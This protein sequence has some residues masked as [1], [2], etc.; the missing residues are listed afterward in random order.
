MKNRRITLSQL[1]GFL[2]KASE[3]L[4]G[5]M[6]ASEFKEFI[7]GML[8][9]KRM[10][11]EFDLQRR[12]LAK[13]CAHLSAE[14]LEA[15]LEDPRSYPE[16]FFVPRIARW[17]EGFVDETGAAV[18]ALKEVQT[19]AGERL[20]RALAALEDENARL[21]GVLKNNIDFHAEKGKS[22]IP[23]QRWLDLIDHFSHPDFVLVN[24]HFEFPDLLGAAYEYLIKFFADSAGKR[25]GEFYT[26]GEVVQLLVRLIKPREGMSVYDPTVGSGGMLIQSR[27][28]VE[29]QGQHPR[30]LEIYGQEANG[31]VWSI[32]MMNMILHGIQDAQ[33]ENDDT[34]QNPRHRSDRAWRRF[35]RVIANPPF[36]Q[37]YRKADMEFPDRFKY[38]FAPETGKKADLMFVQHMIASLNEHGMM[39]TIMPHGV[40]FRGG[41][42]KVIRAGLINDDLIEAVI[43]LPPALFSGTGI[44]ACVVVINRDKPPELSA[45][46]LFINADAEYA[47]GKNQNRLR[48]EQIEKIDHVF[49]HRLEIPKYSRVVDRSEIVANDFNLNIRRY[50]DNTPEAEPEDVRAHLLG[51]V[52]ASEV[53]AARPIFDKFRFHSKIVFEPHGDGYLTFGHELKDRSVIKDMIENNE[54]VIIICRA[55]REAIA[56]WWNLAR[57]ELAR[58]EGHHLLAQV[59][60]RLLASIKRQL[61]PIGV[62]DE[63]QIAG[64]FV[65]WWQ[66]IRY[67]LKTIISSG[68][69]A[70]LIPDRYLIEA[71]FQ[72]DVEAIAALEGRLGAEESRL[73]EVL[74]SIELETAEDEEAETERN[75]GQ[76][77][78]SLVDQIS[79]LRQSDSLTALTEGA[80]LESQLEA[81]KSCESRIRG[82]KA[83]LKQAQ[84]ELQRS[85][86]WKRVGVD[87]DRAELRRKIEAN[88]RE[89]ARVM[90]EPETEA[91]AERQR[92]KRLEALNREHERFE[93]ELIRLEASLAAIGGVISP[94]EARALILRRHHDL[95]RDELSRYLNAEQRALVAVFEGLWDKYAISTTDLERQRTSMI[96]ELDRFLAEL[97]YTEKSG[98]V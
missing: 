3:V 90:I 40:L 14:E 8:F 17:H 70:G 77:K 51:G 55:M 53:E 56:D 50:V 52:P 92:V 67:D 81:I 58:L 54:N 22:R 27:Q 73:R 44:P 71:F 24:D 64:V 1:E 65:N 19:Q 13:A 4:R 28:Y 34:L 69:Q 33:I 20:N 82:V 59:R 43:S 7:F 63:F 45:K 41:Q 79:D 66:G 15:R 80:T 37:N 38:G 61:L 16:T 84:A 25:G 75:A 68:W 93:A 39:A 29:E 76:V 47:E 31:T 42:E 36:S 74:E 30:R 49:T 6:D 46:V 72:P 2:L 88:K 91:R 10:S 35:D 98:K 62:L 78:A 23:N 96:A 5:K 95:I 89:L 18:P 57:A 60:T 85:L 87:E 32:C 83:E 12:E 26:P 94:E 21:A 11:D 86:H 9:I 97:G 48:P